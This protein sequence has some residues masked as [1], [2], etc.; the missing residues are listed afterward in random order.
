[1]G[2]GGGGTILKV[3]GY[4]LPISTVDDYEGEISSMSES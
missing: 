1:M 4:F 3:D 2:G